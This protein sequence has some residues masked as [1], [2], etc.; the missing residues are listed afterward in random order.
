MPD[1]RRS[2]TESVSRTSK[3]NWVLSS[4]NE[5]DKWTH[6][7]YRKDQQYTAL[8]DLRVFSDDYKTLKPALCRN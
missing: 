3:S 5:G 2:H 7:D 8:V 1:E 6:G 4:D